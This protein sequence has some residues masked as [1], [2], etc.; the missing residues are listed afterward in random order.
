LGRASNIGKIEDVLVIVKVAIL[1]VFVGFGIF[2]LSHNS[3]V[4]LAPHGSGS[5]LATSGLLFIAYLGFS[6]V[7][8]IAGDVRSPKKTIPKAI[9]LSVL[10]VMA[11]YAGVVLALL[12]FPLV[13][14]DESSVGQVAA[15]V[16]GPVGGWAIP[17]AALVSTLSAA[18][19]N[20][21]GSSELMVRLAARKDVPTFAGRLWHGHP[22]VSVLFG[23]AVYGLLLVSGQ[24]ETVIALANVAAIVAIAL[25]DVAA[26]RAM[27][28]PRPG[29]MRLLGGPVLPFLGLVSCVAQLWLVGV[30]PVALG[31]ILVA[32][33]GVLYLGRKIYHNPAAHDALI[34]SLARHGGPALRTL[35]HIDGRDINT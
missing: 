14:Y 13:H 2:H 19:S 23:A 16:L 32:L 4:P 30:K 25:V 9:L 8:N 33:G 6:V 35:R 24:T 28:R 20:I 17:I 27:L 11:L 1:V 15:R 34:S 26:I 3:F 31:L 22:V 5:V 7:T 18:N 10:I 21:L 29:M 12:A